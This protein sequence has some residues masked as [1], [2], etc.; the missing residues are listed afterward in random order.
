MH[1]GLPCQ[2]VRAVRISQR[3]I[4]LITQF[5]LFIMAT[6]TALAYQGFTTT[7]DNA[8]VDIEQ[9]FT[10]SVE[11]DANNKSQRN[12][13]VGTFV[14]RLF[15]YLALQ[16]ATGA[17]FANLS[18]PLLMRFNVG[19]TTIDLGT[20]DEALQSRLKVGHNAKAK[21]AFA[22]RVKAI[23]EFL[24]ETPEV[25]DIDDVIAGLEDIIATDAVAELTK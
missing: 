3:A 23:V 4:A 12:Q 1:Q 13:V 18:H 24:L 5:N 14:S 19:K 6:F 15:R 9:S 2:D 25:V 7:R 17:R 8:L 20:I 16:Q 10:F 22:V 11:L 21:R